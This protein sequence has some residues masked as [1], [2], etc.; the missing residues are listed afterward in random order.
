MEPGEAGQ[1]NLDMGDVIYSP[2]V[3]Y[4]ISGSMKIFFSINHGLLME[5]FMAGQQVHIIFDTSYHQ[6]LY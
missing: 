6:K 2:W 5:V 1:D 4:L 3:R